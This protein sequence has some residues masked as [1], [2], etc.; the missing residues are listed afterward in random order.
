MDPLKIEP[1]V[2]RQ[3]PLREKVK[4]AWG[5]VEEIPC[6]VAPLGDVVRFGV[7]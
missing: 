5:S 6:T 7:R 1:A 4:D 3:Y 2:D